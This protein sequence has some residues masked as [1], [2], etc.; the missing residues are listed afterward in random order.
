M[1]GRI[2]PGGSEE[3]CDQTGEGGMVPSPARDIGTVV[4]VTS[5]LRGV[6]WFACVGV[7]RDA[8]L[9]AFTKATIF[10]TVAFSTADA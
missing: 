6:I 3:H 8:D 4:P 1:R 7:G 2:V 5:L 9:Y 10:Q